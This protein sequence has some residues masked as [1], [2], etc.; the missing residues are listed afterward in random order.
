MRPNGKDL[1]T[2]ASLPLVQSWEGSGGGGGGDAAQGGLESLSAAGFSPPSLLLPRGPP[3]LT[4]RDPWPW[5]RGTPPLLWQS[6]IRY[7][8]FSAWSPCSRQRPEGGLGGVAEGRG[9]PPASSSCQ[10]P[11][12]TQTFR[13]QRLRGPGSHQGC[14]T[15]GHQGSAG[16]LRGHSQPETSQYVKS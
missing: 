12:P 11:P 1:V 5:G 15:P 3:S 10:R 6:C 7:S 14:A 16:V 13:T 8:K 4:G 9:E 2:Q